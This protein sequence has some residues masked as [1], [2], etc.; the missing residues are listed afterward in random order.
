MLLKNEDDNDGKRLNVPEGLDF[1]GFM[2]QEAVVEH[3]TEGGMWWF[4][5]PGKSAW[6]EPKM[7]SKSEEFLRFTEAALW[8]KRARKIVRMLAWTAEDELEGSM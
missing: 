2:A 7:M 5:M 8:C 6:A 3:G 1:D 4:R